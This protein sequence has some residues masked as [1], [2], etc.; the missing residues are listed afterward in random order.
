MLVRAGAPAAQGL[1]DE[2]HD[3]DVAPTQQLRQAPYSAPTPRTI[4]GGKVL[5]TPAL[6]RMLEAAPPPLLIDVAGSEAHTSVAGAVW[7]GGVGH[8]GNFIDILQ[9]ELQQ[10]LQV[11]TGGDKS[12]EIVF[13]C[14][15]AKCWL[16]Y[17]AA[18]RAIAL[19]YARVY[20][21][22]G[23]ILAWRAAGLPLGKTRRVE[24]T[25]R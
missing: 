17:N 10:S 15:D 12:R 1:A 13:L 2:E 24:Q 5:D 16:S 8:G 6:R 18:L 20:W 4:P 23:G 21:Y 19:G 3:W 11:L 14:V 7:L 25:A 22:R 9:A